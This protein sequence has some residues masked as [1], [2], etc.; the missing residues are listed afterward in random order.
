MKITATIA[1]GGQSLEVTVT[2]NEQSKP[3]V[4]PVKPNGQGSAING[5]ELLLLSLAT[6]FCN[7]IYR[8]A[9]NRNI[10]VSR[11]EV[12]ATGEF[13]AA[14]EPG[15]NFRYRTRVIAD[16]SDEAINDL[17]AHTDSVAEIHNTLRKGLA[18]TVE[19]D[20]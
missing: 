12:T 17:I 7:D 3:V 5:G 1:S 20:R 16:A 15:Y 6:C 19:P 11:V 14:G 4:L 18:I 13:G 10:A 2:T 8:E 9:A